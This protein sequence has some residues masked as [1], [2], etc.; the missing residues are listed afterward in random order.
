MFSMS[1]IKVGRIFG[2]RIGVN[3]SW[4]LVLFLFIFLLSSSFTSVLSGNKTDGYLVAVFATLLFFAS[5]VLHEIGHAVAA[6]RSGIEVSGIDL[7]FFGGVMRMN[8]DTDSPGAEF[9]VAVAGPLVTLAIIVVFS[10]IGMAISGVNGFWDAAW[11]KSGSTVSAVEL[12]ISF[13]VSMNVLLLV[14]NLVPAFPLDGGRIA[15]AIIWKVTGDRSRATVIAASIGRAF[16]YLL[17][18]AGLFIAFYT[19]NIFGGLW[20]ILLGWMLSQ[21]ARAAIIQNQVAERLAGVTV[22]GIMDPEPITI[23]S[24]LSVQEAFNDFFLRYYDW[25]WF[26]LVDS[27]NRYVGIVSRKDIEHATHEPVPPTNLS[28]IATGKDLQNTVELDTPLEAVLGSE[29]LRKYGALMVLDKA[30]QLCGVLTLGQVS[31]A[32]QS[33]LSTH[34]ATP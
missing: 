6:R 19:A 13:L 3:V 26:A 2:I 28:T 24:D 25:D 30:G 4:F 11:L 9:K 31:K 8:R 32:L 12:L 15:R 5:I 23:P 33:R 29:G 16:A 18:L 20:L 27:Y 10:A 7:I 1:S 34:G 14:F 21:A 22:A 17:M